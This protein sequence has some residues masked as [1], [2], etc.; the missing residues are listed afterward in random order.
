MGSQTVCH[1]AQGPHSKLTGILE[2]CQWPLTDFPR[3]PILCVR[4]LEEL[5]SG[6]AARCYVTYCM[7]SVNL[8]TA[9]KYCILFLGTTLS[10]I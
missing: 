5:G 6:T 10:S 3:Q 1:S 2:R 8:G 4:H 9:K 7:I